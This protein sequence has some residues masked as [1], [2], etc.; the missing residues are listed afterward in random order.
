MSEIKN[1]EVD[2]GPRPSYYQREV[3]PGGY[4]VTKAKREQLLGATLIH[5]NDTDYSAKIKVFLICVN[6]G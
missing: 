5:D 1:I 6:F 4:S 3:T 2:W